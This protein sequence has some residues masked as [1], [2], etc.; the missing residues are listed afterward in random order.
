MAYPQY[1]W[2]TLQRQ[3]AAENEVNRLEWSSTQWRQELVKIGQ[4][5]LGELEKKGAAK[6][7]INKFRAFIEKA[8]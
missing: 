8:K 5:V 3:R 4:E 2:W 7:I 6:D 1:P